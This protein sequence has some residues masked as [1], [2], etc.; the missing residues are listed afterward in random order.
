MKLSL[1][2]NSVPITLEQV[3]GKPDV[4]YTLR[5][6]NAAQRDAYLDSMQGRVETDEAGKVKSIKSFDGMHADLLT[7]CLFDQAG[8]AVTR[9]VVQAWPASVTGALFDK[10]NELNHVNTANVKAEAKKA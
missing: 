9:E 2:I 7:R 5:E 6:M 3:D 8:K 10:A 1:K 4:I